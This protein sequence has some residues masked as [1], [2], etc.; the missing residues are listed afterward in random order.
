MPNSRYFFNTKC[1]IVRD[2]E[3]GKCKHLSNHQPAYHRELQLA[4]TS[5]SQLSSIYYIVPSKSQVGL[6]VKKKQRPKR[7]NEKHKNSKSES[8][9]LPTS[10]FFYESTFCDSQGS[11]PLLT[12]SQRVRHHFQNLRKMMEVHLKAISSI[13][14]LKLVAGL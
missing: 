8:M 12:N 11:R 14:R 10:K 5:T 2:L 13:K 7:V 1:C 3:L 6:E 4:I 9:A